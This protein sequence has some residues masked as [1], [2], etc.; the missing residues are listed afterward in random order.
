[1]T[2]AAALSEKPQITIRELLDRY[3]DS[4]DFWGPSREILNK[5]SSNA[6]AM[7]GLTSNTEAP[8]TKTAKVYSDVVKTFY[9]TRSQIPEKFK[10]KFLNLRVPVLEGANEND[11]K[12]LVNRLAEVNSYD[13]SPGN[14]FLQ[15]YINSLGDKVYDQGFIKL[16]SFKK[17]IFNKDYLTALSS[18]NIGLVNDISLKA[19]TDFKFDE[20]VKT[21][22][23]Q[24]QIDAAKDRILTNYAQNNIFSKY[25]SDNPY[26]VDPATSKMAAFLGLSA[27]QIRSNPALSLYFDAYADATNKNYPVDNYGRSLAYSPL[28][29][30]YTAFSANSLNFDHGDVTP[31]LDRLSKYL[32]KSVLPAYGY[33][34]QSPEVKD[35]F[36]SMAQGMAQAQAHDEGNYL[37]PADMAALPESEKLRL[38]NKRMGS[39]ITSWD[40]DSL[41]NKAFQSMTDLEVLERHVNKQVG[42]GVI[43]WSEAQK[44]YD[45]RENLLG[46]FQDFGGELTSRYVDAATANRKAYDAWLPGYLY[47]LNKGTKDNGLSSG[48]KA[49]SV[50]LGFVLPGLGT[51]IGS[52]LG[53]GSG[54]LGTALGSAI[55]GGAT[56]AISGGDPLKGAL[57]G[58]FG[59][60]LNAS[61]VV[62]NIGGAIGDAF[63]VTNPAIQSAINAGVSGALKGTVNAAVNGSGFGDA[64]EFGLISGVAS[65]A[66]NYVGGLVKGVVDGQPMGN[67]DGAWTPENIESAQHNTLANNW[68]TNNVDGNPVSPE[69]SLATT[70]G[71]AAGGATSGLISS[72][73]TGGDVGNAVLTGALTG[74]A[75][76]AVTDLGGSPG[77]ANAAGG[78]VNAVVRNELNEPQDYTNVTTPPA[79]VTPNPPVTTGTTRRPFGAVGDDTFGFGSM[80]PF[81]TD[82]TK[83]RNVNYN[84]RNFAGA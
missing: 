52:A 26:G 74:A 30:G 39:N 3:Y 77:M 61:G 48:L 44:F 57:L 36:M 53:A 81:F 6:W 11:Y 12:D 15:G 51:A 66:G 28:N 56:S 37:Q 63:D 79:P 8:D 50:G 41:R 19:G 7:S 54:A 80:L 31:G 70:L 58:G 59:G 84:A 46:S 20:L 73:L 18:G 45:L 22:N 42:E 13:P 40:Y 75:S 65:G 24:S 34:V 33:D 4:S 72:S 29:T 17:D 60:Y 38:L 10:E 67:G 68:Y 35:S 21:H 82:L 27:D 62:G 14:N 78:L 1:M 64:L 23:A 76:G 69:F 32:A 9:P 5:A 25:V 47:Q 49:L 2:T 83:N 71:N 16:E 55:V 43:P